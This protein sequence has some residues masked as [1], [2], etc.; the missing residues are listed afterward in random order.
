MTDITPNPIETKPR[1]KKRVFLWVFLAIQAAFITWLIVG[2]AGAGGTPADCGTLSAA[3]C[4]DAE[5]V[6]AGIGLFLVV[7]LWMITD[8][9]VGGGYAIYRLA[10]RS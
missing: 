4:N 5:V 8:F 2:S 10:K 7:A 9:L 3:T 6:G 1:R